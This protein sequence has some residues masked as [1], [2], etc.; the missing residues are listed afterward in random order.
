MQVW[1][2]LKTLGSHFMSFLVSFM[3]I[4]VYWNSHHRYMNLIT[5]IDVRLILLNMLFLLSITLM[6]FVSGLFG[7]YFY[8]P[9]G[10][11]IYAGAIAFT[12]F[13]MKAI[14]L[15]LSHHP[16]ML[17]PEV[18]T[19]FVRKHNLLL[20]AG[21]IAFLVSIPFAWISFTAV[22]IVWFLTPIST[23]I[24]TRNVLDKSRK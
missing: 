16:E 5:K 19:T 17:K 22:I 6:P 4:G 8:L 14:W 7:Q 15:Y 12:G 20:L 24:I 13:S 21:P 9:I 1:G 11:A 23:F 10:S 3:V 2:Q 18:S